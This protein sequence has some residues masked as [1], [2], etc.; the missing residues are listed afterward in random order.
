MADE[1]E[2]DP[3]QAFAALMSKAAE[4]AAPES[5]AAPFG[6]MKDPVTGEERPRKTRGRVA[7][8]PSLDELKAEREAEAAGIND[9]ADIKG[10]PGDRA[11]QT[12]RR[13]KRGR[14]EPKPP[15]PE[16]P[17][18]QFREGQIAK[19]MNRLYRKAGKMIRVMDRDIGQ[20]FIDITRKEDEE[21]VTVGEAWEEFARANPRI[22]RLLLK[23]IAGGAMGQLFMAHAPIFLA[24]LMKDAIRRHIPFNRLFE[25]FLDGGEDGEAPADGTPMEGVTPGD[26]QEAMAFAQQMAEQMMSGR[27]M[28]STPRAPASDETA[29]QP[30]AA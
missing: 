4:E 1:V 24:F 22:R 6:Y 23:L 16:Q 27:G 3:G 15:K 26:M 12:G 18:P 10:E 9:R 8:S 30:A 20:A 11:P 2:Q 28:S 7:K 19:G 25:A 14:G 5:A 17:T 13:R 29:D 21:D